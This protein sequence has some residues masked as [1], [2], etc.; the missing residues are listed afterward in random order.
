MILANVEKKEPPKSGDERD[1]VSTYRK[2]W[3]SCKPTEGR[4]AAKVQI[5]R[6]ARRKN[7]QEN[8]S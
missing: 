5:N 7:K 8:D 3:K 2:K 1:A 4:K 6:R